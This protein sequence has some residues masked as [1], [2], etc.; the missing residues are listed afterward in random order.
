VFAGLPEKLSVRSAFPRLWE[1][2]QRYGSLIKGAILGAR[3]RRKRQEQS[4]QNA[5]SFSFKEGLQTLIDALARAL[6]DKVRTGAALRGLRREE[7]GFALELA[8]HPEAVRARAVVLTI[9][10]HA[11]EGLDLG[12]D[13]EAARHA[14]GQIYYPPVAVV[15]CGYRRNPLG[16]P[17]DGFGFLV[18]RRENRQILG[19][20]W[21]SSLFPGRAPE[22][23]LALTVFVGGS[24]QPENA[25]WPEDKLFGVVAEE[26]QALLGLPRP[27]LQRIFRWPRAIPQ[28]QVGHR[29]LIAA[30]EACEA[31]HPG[32]YLGGNFRGGISVADCVKSAHA[33]A[34]KVASDLLAG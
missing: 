23:G 19:S 20:L 8:G 21:N 22:G 24:R 16:Q 14:L 31:R 27:D 9:P 15:F 11:Y 30:V 26:L 13:C 3:E 34:D 32:L 1:L 18:P 10:A 5:Q 4:K 29:Q 28:Y 2:E 12:F 7:A 33:L 6:G 17:L 25:R